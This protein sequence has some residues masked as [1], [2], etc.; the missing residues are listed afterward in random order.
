VYEFVF[1]DEVQFTRR[2]WRNRNRLI[3][4]DKITWLTIPLKN[5]GNYFQKI[6]NM[7]TSIMDSSSYDYLHLLNPNF[8]ILLF[9]YR[10]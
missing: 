2:D 10:N 8:K 1:L 5:K 7:E 6:K 4:N 9:D 3:F